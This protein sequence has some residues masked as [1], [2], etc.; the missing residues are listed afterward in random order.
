MAFQDRA[1]VLALQRQRHLTSGVQRQVLVL[2]VK[3]H[4]TL[5]LA[6]ALRRQFP[7]PGAILPRAIADMSN[8]GLVGLER[9][10]NIQ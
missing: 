1:R 2:R 3:L 8:P 10:V 6:T 9:V 5:Q 4:M 7:R